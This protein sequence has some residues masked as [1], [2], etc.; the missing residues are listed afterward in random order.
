VDAEVTPPQPE[1]DQAGGT[2]REGQDDDALVALETRLLLDAVHARY[3]HDFREYA[4]ASLKRRLQQAL[5]ALGFTSISHLQHAVLRQPAL[6]SRL[7]QFLT[8]QVSDM[9]RDPVY[10]RA[11][12]QQVLP[13]LLTY[14]SIKIWVAGCSHGEEV[15]SLL[16]LLQEEGLL[17][18]TVVYA[19]DINPDALRLA[20]AGVFPLERAAAFSRNYQAAGGRGSLTDHFT[21]GYEGIVFDRHLRR[22][23]VFADH[24]LATDAVFSEMHLVS[25]RNVMIYFND[26]L[27]ARAVGLFRDSLVRRG[28]LGLG[29]RESLRF[30][31]HATAF[32]VAFPEPDVR[33]Y[34]RL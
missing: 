18:R 8:V 16:V 27:Q 3:Q 11:L 29:S 25:C 34:R 4:P 21:S 32:E 19:T 31:P 6:F 7:L 15:W 33:L 20:E 30:N 12:R 22:Q 10:F 14:P 13:E 17:E 5:P 28:Y 24:S 26:K 2:R 9:F 23:V 1:P